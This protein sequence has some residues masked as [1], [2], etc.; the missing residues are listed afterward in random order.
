[1]TATEDCRTCKE[2]IEYVGYTTNWDTG[3]RLRKPESHIKTWFHVGPDSGHTP[4][5]TPRCPKCRSTNYV[6]DT[7]DPWA[8]YTRCGDCG[9]V[10]RRSLGD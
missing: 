8:D 10:D 1:M 9:H 5:P 6:H 2:P 3:Q 7:S 4:E